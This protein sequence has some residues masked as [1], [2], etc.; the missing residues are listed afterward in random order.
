MEVSIIGAG[1]FGTALAQMISRNVDKVTIIA[2]DP[3]VVSSIN[4]FHENPKYHPGV[5]LNENIKAELIQ[6]ARDVIKSSEFIFISV[7]SGNVRSVVKEFSQE[8]KDKFIISGSKGI[9]YPSLKTMTEIITEETNSEQVFSISGPT[10]AVELIRGIPSGLT[11]GAPKVYWNDIK[12]LL[13]SPTVFLDYSEKVKGVELCG[14]LKNIYAVGMGIFENYILGDNDMYLFLTISFKE[15]ARV[16][17][18]FEYEEL[19]TKFCG[20]GD[21]LLTTSSNKSRNKTLG[22]MLGKKMVLSEDSSATIESLKSIKAIRVLTSEIDLPVLDL[23]L[24]IIKNPHL[25][26]IY[27]KEFQRIIK[28]IEI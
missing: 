4:N 18:H 9:E 17:R 25:G 23:V 13:E 5:K 15:M 26:S 24:N 21:F 6:R 1:S 11:V 28:I 16:L 22:L 10:F 2:R 7:P 12:E 19:L 3:E 14:I 20:V 27:I 8:L